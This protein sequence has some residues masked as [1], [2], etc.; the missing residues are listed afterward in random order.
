MSAKPFSVTYTNSFGERV[1]ERPRLMFSV[2][3]EGSEGPDAIQYKSLWLGDATILATVRADADD[4]EL[5]ALA[6]AR[7]P[8]LAQ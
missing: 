8:L 3:S 1:A 7:V 4:A 6:K 5:W 2:V